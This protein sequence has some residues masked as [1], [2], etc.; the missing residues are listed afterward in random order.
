M[1]DLTLDRYRWYLD[2][3]GMRT[4]LT[5]AERRARTR[6][7]LIDAA[8]RLFTARGFHATSLDS[9]AAEAGYTKGAV[10][11]NFASKEDLFFAVY[12]RRLDHRL[13]EFEAIFQ[14]TPTALDGLRQAARTA[15]PRSDRQ[16]GWL[17]VFFEFW[18]HVLR[19]EEL[20]GRFAALHRRI[21]APLETALLRHAEETG[22][23]L[24]EDPQKMAVAR[25][26]M[27]LGLQLERLTQP[28]LVDPELG[29]RM[30]T[31]SI[32]GGTQD[33]LPDQAPA[34]LR[35]RRAREQGPARA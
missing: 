34:G 32:D 28:E 12:E 23:P 17:A 18:A 31:L 25:Y 20:R 13:A 33:G 16:D 6:T 10:Y 30:L 1:Q 3:V 35:K 8:E 22:V 7:D 5:R 21:V 24:P 15:A 26:A 19:H 14:T 29:A 4:V 2:T 9:V 27:Q 11:S